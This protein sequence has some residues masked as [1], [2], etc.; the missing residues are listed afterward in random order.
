MLQQTVPPRLQS[1]LWSSNIYTINLKKDK[2]YIIHQILAYGDMEDIKWLFATYPR[3]TIKNI[4]TTTPYKDYRRS[5]FYFIK[6]FVM[7]L[8]QKPFPESSY[9]KNIPRAI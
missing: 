4:F 7:D 9:V 6:D 2:T 5:R 3:T 1:V 8:A